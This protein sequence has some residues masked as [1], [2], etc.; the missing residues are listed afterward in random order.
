MR[1]RVSFNFIN[2]GFNK[3]YAQEFNGGKESAGNMKS[4]SGS[5]CEVKDVSSVELIKNGTYQLDGKFENGAEYNFP[6]PNVTMFRCHLEN[7]TDLDFAVSASVLNKTQ[8]TPNGRYQIT[9]CYFYINPD[10]ISVALGTSLIVNKNEVPNQLLI[11]P[12]L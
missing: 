12:G 10:P 7:G 2:A 6:I 9:R 11:P 1:V 3:K 8:K 5:T 4:L